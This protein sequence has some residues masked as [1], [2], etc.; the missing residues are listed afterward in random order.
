MKKGSHKGILAFFLTGAFDTATSEL[1]CTTLSR[2]LAL[3][4][5]SSKHGNTL[6]ASSG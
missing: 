5:G 4:D 2:N 6:R 3:Y 1:S